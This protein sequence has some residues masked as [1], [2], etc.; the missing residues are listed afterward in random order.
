[1]KT[2][3]WTM[4][5][6]VVAVLALILS[7]T[8]QVLSPSVSNPDPAFADCYEMQAEG[9]DIGCPEIDTKI[10]FERQEV[11]IYTPAAVTLNFAFYVAV[12]AGLLVA[13]RLLWHNKR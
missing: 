10:G 9:L 8:Y 6:G 1:M 3:S 11:P 12:G 13:T 4:K 5:L 2:W 7:L